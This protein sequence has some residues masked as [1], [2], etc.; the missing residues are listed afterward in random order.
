MLK[1][2][3]TAKRGKAKITFVLQPQTHAH[4]V[5]HAGDFNEWRSATPM[6][7][8]KD[9]SWRATLE[10][11]AGREYE[12]RYLV[13]GSTWVNDDGA[14]AYVPNPFGGD[15]SVVRVEDM[16]T[17]QRSG[18]ADAAGSELDMATAGGQGTPE[19]GTT[20]VPSKRGGTGSSRR[21]TGA[22]R[23]GGSGPRKSRGR[24]GGVGRRPPHEPDEDSGGSRS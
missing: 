11:D 3:R 2:T 5:H 24:Q 14:D 8:Q 15:K 10:L 16:S 18:R 7:R 1:K 4:Q 22:G 20:D 17:M 9:G 13:D 6:R 23:E 19:T 21:G 12:F